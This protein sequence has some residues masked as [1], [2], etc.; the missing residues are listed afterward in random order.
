MY[1]VI[2]LKMGELVLKGL[3][4]HT[5]EARLKKNIKYRLR[6]F[7]R[8][9]LVSLQSTIYIIPVDGFDVD[10]AYSA[11]QKIFG[12]SR[13][14]LAAQCEKDMDAIK[15][16]AVEYLAGSLARAKTFKVEARRADKTFPF[17]SPQIAVQVA[18]AL[19]DANPH[20]DADMKNPQVMVTVEVRDHH[21][22]VHD[23]GV[24]GAGG[25]PVGING[26][27]MLLL[28]GGIDSPVAGHMIS[29]R[30]IQLE[31]IHF[32]SY[33]YTS[34][35][36]KKKVLDLAQIMT[37][38]TGSIQLHVVSF[39]KI[40]EQIRDKCAPDMFTIVMRA[41]MMKIATQLAKK[42]GCGGL[43]TGESLGQVASQT[44]QAI[45]VTSAYSDLPILRP[46]IG[47]DK[48][49]IVTISRK[50]GAFET[51]ILPHE[52]CCTVFTPKHP[53]TKPKLYEVQAELEKL[54]VDAL[55]AQALESAE[56]IDVN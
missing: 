26:S 50:I 21:A 19:G 53:K 4:R 48:E 33:P 37:E 52:D 20:L 31:A 43:I 23:S 13:V 30:G 28:S 41:F 36:A 12:L 6:K 45:G 34:E 16:T 8:Y 1:R 24:H 39:T 44:M 49:E 35:L 7:G 56:V 51:S 22:Y 46:V 47:M 14:C 25:L 3:N 40:Q 2:L 10:G 27:A 32:F 18:E 38:Y 9:E 42:R 29:K 17:G 11:C 5:F 15:A 55:V 54:E